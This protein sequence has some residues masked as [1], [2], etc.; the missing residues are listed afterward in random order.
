M[1]HL[2]AILLALALGCGAALQASA[3]ALTERTAW[4]LSEGDRTDDNVRDNEIEVSSKDGNIYIRTPRRVQVT[5]YTILGQIVTER[6]LNPG[7]SE[8]KIGTRGIYLVKIEGK[9]QKVAL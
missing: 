8:L 1:K 3:Q 9:T 4:S 2:Y 7:I 5:V 6:T